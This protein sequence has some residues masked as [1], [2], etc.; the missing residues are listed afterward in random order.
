VN[1]IADVK[2]YRAPQD[3]QL[4]WTPEGFG[5]Y[6]SADDWWRLRG[7]FLVVCG[8]RDIYKMERDAARA[9]LLA[10]TLGLGEQQSASQEKP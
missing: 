8:D 2:F 4:E 3:R 1:G 5:T 7:A 6:V 9:E 10:L